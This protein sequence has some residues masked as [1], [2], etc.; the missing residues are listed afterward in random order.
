M[1]RQGKPRDIHSACTTSLS[2]ASVSPLA[3]VL[4]FRMIATADDQG[5]LSGDPRILKAE[6]CPMRED[7]N[8]TNIAPLLEELGHEKMIMLYNDS[9]SNSPIIQLCNWWT[10]QS[11]QWAYPSK[12]PPAPSWVDHLRYKKG[13]KVL[14]RNW[15]PTGEV[16]PE[17]VEEQEDS[18]DPLTKETPQDSVPVDSLPPAKETWEKV[19]E[20]LQQQVSKT[21]YTT[22]LKS[23]Q[24]IHW[25][26]DGNEVT[27]LVGTP[28]A[29]I[30]QWLSKRFHSVTKKALAAV[31]GD[32]FISRDVEIQFTVWQS[33]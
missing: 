19:L 13:G 10:Y 22:W 26:T 32:A 29:H 7:I 23:S 9:S 33:T 4:F 1:A 21:N 16:S 28:N 12:Y 18:S 25:L 5:R 17:D 31:V 24:G 15:P 20:E 6:A 11:Q 27:L 14:T 30:A 3:E 2:L 8:S